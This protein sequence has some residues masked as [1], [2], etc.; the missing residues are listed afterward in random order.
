[1]KVRGVVTAVNPGKANDKGE[2]TTFISIEG[3]SVIAG[4]SLSRLPVVNE[5]IVGRVDV[6][7]RGKGERPVH[8]LNEFVAAPI[9]V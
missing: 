7:W 3:F 9:S 4:G 2:I 6:R 1:M 8:I 5:E